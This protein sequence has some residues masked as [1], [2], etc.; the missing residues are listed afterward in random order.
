[1]VFIIDPA[2]ISDR[3]I[4]IMNKNRKVHTFNGTKYDLSA[5]CVMII[6]KWGNCLTVVC[7]LCTEKIADNSFQ[8]HVSIYTS[9]SSSFLF[10]VFV[11]YYTFRQMRAFTHSLTLTLSHSCA[12]GNQHQHHYWQW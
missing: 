7:K 6:M 9:R 11:R 2:H 1:M 8:I 4:E 3:A 5:C 10:D 12:Q